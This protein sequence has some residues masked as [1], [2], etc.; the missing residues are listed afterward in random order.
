M[1]VNDDA[2]V[3][4]FDWM[5]APGLPPASVMLSGVVMTMSAPWPGLVA[6]KPSMTLPG[7][8]TKSPVVRLMVRG[9]TPAHDAGLHV[10]LIV[11]PVWTMTP[12][13]TVM[14]VPPAPEI[15]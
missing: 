3:A 10:T 8:I 13:G 12:S 11:A 7:C 5:I 14:V 15:T 4:W 1:F 6:V 9:P 2:G